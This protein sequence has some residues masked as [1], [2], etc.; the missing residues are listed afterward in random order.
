MQISHSGFF[1]SDL[2]KDLAQL[3][4]RFARSLI[5]SHDSVA[6]NDETESGADINAHSLL[7]YDSNDSYDMKKTGILWYCG[8]LWYIHLYFILFTF[9]DLQLPCFINKIL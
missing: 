6:T 9:H 2:H 3:I 7:R 5:L 1:T 8:I 4:F